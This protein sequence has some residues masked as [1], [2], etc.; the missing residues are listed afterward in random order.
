MLIM[1]AWGGAWLHAV[2]GDESAEGSKGGQRVMSQ[3]STS[4]GQRQSKAVSHRVMSQMEGGQCG[5]Q[6]RSMS[7]SCEWRL[8]GLDT[9]Q[10]PVGV[11][12]K[13][14]VSL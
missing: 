7:D 10:R 6:R 12:S 5:G 14:V 8:P 11:F 3:V 4:R 1:G 2:K 13:G 9:S